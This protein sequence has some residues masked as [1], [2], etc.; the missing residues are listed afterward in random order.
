M[1]FFKQ[2][3]GLPGACK[4][5]GGDSCVNVNDSKLAS[6]LPLYGHIQE[7]CRKLTTRRQEDKL[8]CQLEQAAF[9]YAVS[10]KFQV[11]ISSQH[12]CILNMFKENVSSQLQDI[13][14]RNLESSRE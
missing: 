12:A 2:A 14:T 13:C 5:H 7:V 10:I 4:H 6:F 9:T 1:L 3:S 8:H 11:Q